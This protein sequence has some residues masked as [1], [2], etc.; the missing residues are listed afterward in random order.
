MTE[1]P[2][3]QTIEIPLDLKQVDRS[4]EMDCLG[5]ILLKRPGMLHCT[6]GKL[7]V[8]IEGDVQD[9]QL[10]EGEQLPLPE[11]RLCLMEGSATFVLAPDTARCGKKVFAAWQQARP[12]IQKLGRIVRELFCLADT[13]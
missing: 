1:L 4:I 2:S 9:Y 3:L 6:K 7:L 10:T 12:G 13:A 8:T 11:H 5:K